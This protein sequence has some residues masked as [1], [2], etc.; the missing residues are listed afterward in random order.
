MDEEGGG[1]SP[2]EVPSAALDR[3][4]LELHDQLPRDAR[5]KLAQ[6]AD[7]VKRLTESITAEDP[8][9]PSPSADQVVVRREEEIATAEAKQSLG[10]LQAQGRAY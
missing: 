10:E 3:L 6:L 7:E 5:G 9:I 2:R 1:Q 4:F 8:V